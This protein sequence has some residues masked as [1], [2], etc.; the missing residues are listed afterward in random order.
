MFPSMKDNSLNIG[1]KKI[2]A[3]K[4]ALANSKFKLIAEDVGGAHGRRISFNVITGLVKIR[5][6]TG[7]ERVHLN[8]N[9][10]LHG[11]RPAVDLMMES[12]AKSYGSETLGVLLT[13]MGRDW[14]L[15]M[16]SV[17]QCGG[18]TIA[19][20]KDSC[21]IFGMPKAAIDEGCVD[22][23]LPLPLIAREI[24]NSCQA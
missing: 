1:A 14:A 11:V 13:G 20:D 22:K 18:L 5:T 6:H 24:M 2:A 19:Q 21:V 15:G 7:D 16:K 23:V 3:V 4:S 17:K 10:H 12:A 9:P 8:T